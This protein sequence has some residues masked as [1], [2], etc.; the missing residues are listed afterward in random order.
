MD[1]EISQD[2]LAR[3]LNDIKK[4]ALDIIFQYINPDN[5]VVFLFGSL[6][7]GETY[8]G[9]DVDIGI[10]TTEKIVNESFAL[11]K[12]SIHDN[13]KTLRDIDVVNFATLDDQN[14]IKHSLKNI[15][16]WHETGKSKIDFHNLKAL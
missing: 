7:K 8:R 10:Y 2:E 3:V 9:S 13:A 6:A 11:L 14:F 5:C 16:I 1:R 15:D 12:D 4:S